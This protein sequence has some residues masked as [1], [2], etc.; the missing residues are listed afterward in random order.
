MSHQ[1][2]DEYHQKDGNTGKLKPSSTSTSSPPSQQTHDEILNLQARNLL[3]HPTTSLPILN[4]L[5]MIS[6]AL[7]VPLLG[8]YFQDAGVHSSSQR[9]LLSS[10]YSM[11]Q[12]V[13]GFLIGGLSDVGFLSRKHFLY[14]S[15][16]GSSLSYG[17]IVCANLKGLIASRILVGLVK[18]TGTISTSMISTYTTKDDRAVYIGR[19]T[20]S[21]TFAFIV[22]PS[23]GGF[24][25]KNVNKKAPALVS[26]ILFVFNFM[27]AALLLPNEKQNRKSDSTVNNVNVAKKDELQSSKGVSFKTLLQN[28][29][30]C[31]TS[32]QLASVIL[33]FL[34]Y[35]WMY[36]ATTYATI[37]SYY[38]K[39]FGIEP[40]FRGYIHSYTNMISFIFQSFFIR[41]TLRKLGNEYNAACLAS[42]GLAFATLLE[43]GSSF[44]LYLLIICPIIAVSHAILRLSLRSL[45]T[46]VAPKQSIG[47]VL[48]ALDVLQ[49]GFAVTVPFYR[50][51][52]FQ[53]LSPPDEK[54]NNSSAP[55]IIGDPCPKM[56]L[57]SS[58]LHWT[59][60]TVALCALLL[61]SKTHDDTLKKMTIQKENDVNKEKSE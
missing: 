56:W 7:V 43:F 49:N 30:T 28:I 23:L 17:L 20:A 52:L 29:K 32:R 40:H 46:L 31:F 11:S 3:L 21:S 42:F 35:N 53:I 9:E 5:D 50:A 14:L 33:S 36:R 6:V 2:Q 58:F 25:Y 18:Q 61:K 45:V 4:M 60:A 39:M 10:L 59:L 13:G 24:L 37:T 54:V 15:F 57:K 1:T 55:S 41:F 47:S 19:L 48:A 12:I 27:L 22:G 16:L 38:E 8:Q 51:L 34:L 44:H 26:S